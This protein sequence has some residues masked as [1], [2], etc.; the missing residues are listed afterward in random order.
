MKT[1]S[2]YTLSHPPVDDD[3]PPG[4]ADS[5]EEVKPLPKRSFREAR[6]DSPEDEG[7]PLSPNKEATKA[8]RPVHSS[9]AAKASWK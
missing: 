4:L 2:P 3:L 5:D 6:S 8:K 1:L 7:P 9:N